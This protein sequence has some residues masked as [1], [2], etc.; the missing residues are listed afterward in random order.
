MNLHLTQF[1]LKFGTVLKVFFKYTTRHDDVV[2]GGSLG[3]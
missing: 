3:L 1:G 2:A